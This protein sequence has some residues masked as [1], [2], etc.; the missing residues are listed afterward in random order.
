MRSLDNKT[1]KVTVPERIWAAPPYDDPGWETG[2][3][4]WDVSENWAAEGKE[5][6]IHIDLHQAEVAAAYERAA[7]AAED[8]PRVAP[9]YDEWTRYDEQ[10]AHSQKCIRALATT[11][12]T[13][14][15]D[16]LIAE[17]VGP[18]VDALRA[19]IYHTHECERELTEALYH[20]DFCGESRPLTDA[21]AILA[22]SKK[23]GA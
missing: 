4:E 11:E 2:A 12:Q 13:A 3:G 6:F 1:P 20:A 16:R 15:L 22:A 5:C 14:A 19:L 23:G 10:I 7:D 17:A 8:Y 18:Y 9:D 21:R